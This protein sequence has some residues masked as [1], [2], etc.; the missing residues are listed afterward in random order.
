MTR[1]LA[2]IAVVAV[3]CA[4]G[5]VRADQL[6]SPHNLYFEEN[7][8]SGQ[9]DWYADGGIWEVGIPTA[10]DAHQ[11]DSCAGTNIDG[12][13]PGG[14]SSRFISPVIDLPP[15]DELLDGV[16]WLR[17]WHYW[18][19]SDWDYGI[20]EVSSWDGEAWSAFTSISTSFGG[21]S[22]VWTP[23]LVDIS[24]Y[25]GQTIRLG[26]HHVE[27][28]Y[29]QAAGW[30]VDELAILDGAFAWN[31]PESFEARAWNEVDWGGWFADQ[32]IWEIGE[33]T[34]GPGQAL[35]GHFCAA[36]VLAGNYPGGTSSRLI[37]PVVTLPASPLAGE[38]WL[39]ITHYYDLSDGDIG[40]VQ[41][42]A[43]GAWVDLSPAWGGYSGGWTESILDLAPYAGQTVRFALYFG[44]GGY[45]QAPGW[46]VDDL[47]IV[48]G[49]KIFNTPDSFETGTRGWYASDGIWQVGVP[50]YGP[51]GAHTGV[52]CWGTNLDGNYP[53]GNSSTLQTPDVTL[54]SGVSP[55]RLDFWH[56]W[57]F[58]DYD[59]GEVRIY[60]QGQ[61]DAVISDVFTSTSGGWTHYYIDLTPWSG[62][63]VHF[64]FEFVEGGYYQAP[65]WYIDD[66]RLVGLDQSEPMAPLFVTTVYSPDPPVVTWTPVIYTPVYTCIYAS[67]R[68]DAY[69]PNLGNRIAMLQQPGYSFADTA[70]P[71]WWWYYQVGLIDD[72]QH[73]SLTVASGPPHVGVTD[74]SLPDG[75]AVAV[76]LGAS[77]NPFNPLTTVRFQLLARTH[78]KLQVFDVGGRCV[79]TL[80]DRELEPGIY[81]QPF[82]A[83]RLASG[84]YLGR[85]AAGGTVE[86]SKMVL[87]R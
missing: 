63:T 75:S 3:C 60:P 16:L 9:G 36:T 49:P 62:Q 19:Y 40:V 85:L 77:P 13:Y 47:A 74:E 29:Y 50:T 4:A 12:N 71:G 78:V 32:G 86:T 54:P 84:T 61:P 39:S 73:E 14:A 57:S 8:E 15:A 30:Y 41:I 46:Y 33:P 59:Y 38:L 45:Y 43:D 11:G 23:H 24:A 21:Y 22:A 70:R 67:R 65:G 48:E 27:G 20:V 68:A 31:Q 10:T 82:A 69:F 7:W 56:W 52:A 6:P 81:E 17:F 51:E 26:L 28:G 35:S 87:V 53:G 76:L 1:S 66:V 72:L 25:A 58:S 55:L 42:E 79:A 34:S 64:G 44:E 5:P 2:L 37:S 83:T 18:N 80:V